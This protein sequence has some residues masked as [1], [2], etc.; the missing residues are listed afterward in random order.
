MS[1]GERKEEL[2]SLSGP[3]R[4]RDKIWLSIRRKMAKFLS[5]NLDENVSLEILKIVTEELEN[6]IGM[7][8]WTE[9]TTF[10]KANLQLEFSGE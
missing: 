9:P 1:Y 6:K 7:E 4:I 2:L 8:L 10:I 3:L 5:D